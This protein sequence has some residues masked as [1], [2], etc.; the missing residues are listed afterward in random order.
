MFFTHRILIFWA[1][2]PSRACLECIPTKFEGVLYCWNQWCAWSFKQDEFVT[3]YDPWHRV[4]LPNPGI[5]M[6]Y[7]LPIHHC[8]CRWGLALWPRLDQVSPIVTLNMGYH[9]A[10]FLQHHLAQ[11]P[12]FY[13]L[14]VAVLHHFQVLFLYMQEYLLECIYKRSKSC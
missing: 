5:F 2:R 4:T 6:A 7:Q 11:F 13:C 10:D 9:L 3:Q 1:D 14:I 8:Q 12:S